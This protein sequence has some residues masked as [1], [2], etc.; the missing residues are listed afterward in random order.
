M[1]F[2]MLRAALCC[3]L[4]F[5]YFFTQ[6]Q[7]VK[8]KSYQGT[9]V[10]ENGDTLQG[11][12]RYDFISDG[13]QLERD[14]G[15]LLSFHASQLHHFSFEDPDVKIIRTFYALPVANSSTYESIRFFEV[16]YEGRLTLLAR[17]RSVAEEIAEDTYTGERQGAIDERL[18]SPFEFY[19]LKEG[20]VLQRYQP[21]RNKLFNYMDWRYR[22]VKRYMRRNKLRDDYIADLVRITAYYN[23]LEMR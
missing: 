1:N 21:G 8:Q 6:A 3:G 17:Q 2:L 10:L 13:L 20:G 16:L 9:L 7:T 15:K 18:E 11:T 19:F 22:E 5:A 4:F 14:S 12:L 23:A